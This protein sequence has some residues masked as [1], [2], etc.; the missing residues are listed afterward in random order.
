MTQATNNRI[1]LRTLA[2]CVA[3]AGIGA[4]PAMAEYDP[5]EA[6]A[7]RLQQRQS[8]HDRRWEMQMLE[9]KIE[10]QIDERFESMGGY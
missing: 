1:L 6:W 5:K 8:D 3:V 9:Q 10:R 7:Q 4:T 2:F